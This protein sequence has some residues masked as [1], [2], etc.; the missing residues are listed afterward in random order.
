VQQF[1]DFGLPGIDACEQEL[2]DQEVA[3][4]VHDQAGQLIGFAIHHATTG[5]QWVIQ[6]GGPAA[7]CGT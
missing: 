4:T 7:N 6:H 1:D 3:V 5:T 2:A